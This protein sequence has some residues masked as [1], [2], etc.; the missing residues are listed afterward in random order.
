MISDWL[1][2]LS[3]SQSYYKELCKIINPMMVKISNMNL[4]W[5]AL[6]TFNVS[7]NYK[8]SGWIASNYLAF[9]RLMLVCYRYVRTVIP[10][11]EPG[12]MQCEGKSNRE[13]MPELIPKSSK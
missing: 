3:P 1:T 7:K 2:P 11:T 8:P 4:T 12:L 6:N 5:C 9:A 13:I 10:S